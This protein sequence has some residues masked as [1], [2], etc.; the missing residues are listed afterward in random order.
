MNSILNL[1][2]YEELYKDSSFIGKFKDRFKITYRCE[3][4]IKD[5][6]LSVVNIDI[7]SNVNPKSYYNNIKIAQNIMGFN[8]EPLALDVWRILDYERFNDY[9]KKLFAFSVIK[10]IK[11]FL[12]LNFKN[13]RN[14]CVGVMDAGDYI[15][16]YIIEELCKFGNNVMLLSNNIDY[17]RKEREYLIAEYGVTPVITR[18]YEYLLNN[19]DFIISSRNID[20]ENEKLNIWYIDNR[21]VPKNN[22]NLHVNNVIFQVPWDEKSLKYTPQLIGAILS[23]M[24]GKNVEEDLKSNDINIDS[25]GF[26][27]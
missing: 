2:S 10:S 24:G 25:F 27:L 17:L 22:H 13:I 26:N 20:P 7:P 16:K 3:N 15:N 4:F 6:N 1:K 14:S 12:R 8:C 21:Y 19:S 23:Y 5:I 11:L 9:Q 18:E